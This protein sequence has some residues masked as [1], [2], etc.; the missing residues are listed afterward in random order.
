[1]KELVSNVDIF[2]TILEAIGVPIPENVQGRSFWTL[3]T[4]G[5]Y[6]PRDEVYAELTWHALYDPMRAIRTRRYR[7]IRNFQP[8]WPILIGGPSAQRYGTEMIEKYYGQPRPE[9]ELYDLRIDPWEK[10]NLVGRPEF[11]EIRAELC[12]RLVEFLEETEDPLLEGSVPHPGRKGYECFWMKEGE[13]FG[14]H[15]TI[16]FKEYPI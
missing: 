1:M 11:E 13:K 9:E 6:E 5:G 7:Y 3:L 15:I 4:G 12:G 16:D 2:P 8:G 14:L 10:D